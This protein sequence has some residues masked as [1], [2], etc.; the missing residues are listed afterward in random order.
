[1][2]PGKGRHEIAAMLDFLG[3]YVAQ[4]FNEEEKLMEEVNCP[5]AAVNKQAHARLL[6]EFGDLRKRFDVAGSGSS[7]VLEMHDVLSKWLIERIRGVDVQLRGQVDRPKQDL[8]GA[9]KRS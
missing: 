1:M 7:M 8:V 5:A 6:S 4:H 2:K 3:K 9:A